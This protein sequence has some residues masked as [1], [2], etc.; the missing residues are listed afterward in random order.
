V[1]LA[2]LGAAVGSLI[3]GTLS[4]KIGRKPV[5]LLADI[6][7]TLGAIV[8]AISPTIAILMLGRVL[9]GLGI[10]IAAQIVPLYLAEI[11]PV[12]IRGRLIAFNTLMITTGQLIAVILVF[13]LRPNWR[14]MLGLSGVPSTV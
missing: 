7:F 6:L 12:E 3:A 1:S 13:I 2:L 4:D 5:I 11:A 14:L 8:M 9:V 10:G